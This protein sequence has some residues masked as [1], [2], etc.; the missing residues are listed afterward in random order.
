MLDQAIEALK[1]FDWGTPLATIAPIDDAVAAA[2]DKPED[3]QQLET[4][5]I[6]ALK[7]PIS[8]DAQDYVCRKLAIVGSAASVPTLAVLLLRK[9]NSHMARF[10]LERISDPAA[11]A[12]LR[13]ALPKVTGNLRIGVI[14]SIGARR[15]AE[16]FATLGRFLKDSDAAT[17]RAAA[18]ALGAIGGKWSAGILRAV[19]E[20]GSSPSRGPMI[21]AWLT[22]AESFLANQQLEEAKAIYSSLDDSHQPRLIRLAATRGLL[23]CAGRQ[24]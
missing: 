14:N 11:A 23:A 20:E 21:D 19:I 6:A 5:L 15:D 18:L 1:T 3:R 16:A 4:R 8:R 24:A 7:A 12:A 17:S 22:C 10:A 9:E 2:H 13:D